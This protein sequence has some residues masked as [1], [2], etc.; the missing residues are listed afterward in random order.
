MADGTR[1]AVI[2]LGY[3][4]LPVALAFQRQFPGTI[5][6]DEDRARVTA[7]AAGHD[8]NG[9]VDAAT[10]RA[11]GLRVTADASELAAAEVYVVAVPTPIDGARRPD[12]G[13]LRRAAETV[14]LHLAPGDVVVLESTVYPGLTEEVFGPLL[15]R[16]SGLVAG[17]DFHLA[18]SP[19][20]INPGDREHT[21]E[22]VV[23]VVAADDAATLE[24]V[25]ALYARIVPAG[26]HRAPSIRVAEAAKVIENTQRDVN[27]A[28]MNE[29]AL[30]LD[31]LGL[32]TRDVLDAARTKWNFLPF[33]PGLVGGHC[34]GVDPYYLTAKAEAVGHH[35]E[36]ILAGRRI[37]DTLGEFIAQKVVKLLARRGCGPQGAR[38]GVLGLTFKPDVRD[39]RNSQ[40]PRIVAELVALG[41]DVRLHDPSIAREDALRAVG[42]SAAIADSITELG[43]LDALV[44]AVPHRELR[45]LPVAELLAPLCDGGWVIDVTSALDPHAIEPRWGYWS[46]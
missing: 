32:R 40:V 31:R 41:A 35:P 23:K 11:S 18:Y 28:L 21:L 8:R 17:R 24:R 22:R 42:E 16:A 36:V 46:L 2:G 26:I 33:T 43:A 30:L 1:L 45:E 19:E 13:P 39:L 10:L 29:L 25:A 20:R 9:E 7:L 6:F 15:E 3:V 37:N 27:V 14:G 44:L 12:L 38:V 4:G 5:G 34:V